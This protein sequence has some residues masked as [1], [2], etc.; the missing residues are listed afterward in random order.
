MIEP[1]PSGATCIAGEW[2]P[3]QLP[4]CVEGS[5]PSVRL[6]RSIKSS[7]AGY[8]RRLSK[9]RKRNSDQGNNVIKMD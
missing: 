3:P 2:S 7:E 8:E 1:G 6:P 4:R 5:H 9:R